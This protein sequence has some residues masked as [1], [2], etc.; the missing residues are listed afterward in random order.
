MNTATASA[1]YS[2]PAISS[3]SAVALSTSPMMASS[4]LSPSVAF[5]S[6]GATASKVPKDGSKPFRSV[7]AALLCCGSA[8]PAKAQLSPT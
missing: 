1:A 8:S 6:S 2:S 4:T 7:V 3:V 5:L